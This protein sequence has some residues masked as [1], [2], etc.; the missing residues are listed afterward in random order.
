MQLFYG[1]LLINIGQ[2]Q[3]INNSE[4]LIW[5]DGLYCINLVSAALEIQC[6]PIGSLG[7]PYVS[8]LFKKHGDV[9]G[10]GGCL[11]G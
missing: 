9:Q 1:W 7:E 5:R 8:K 2:M 10:I 11:V 6:C 4:S 3:S